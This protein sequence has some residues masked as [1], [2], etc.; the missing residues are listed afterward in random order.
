[1]K[2]KLILLAIIIISLGFRL[3]GLD[4]DQNQHLHPDER[5][6]TMVLD[7]MR[8]PATID[9]YLDPHLSLL[10]P[11]NLDF[12]FFV[13]GTLPLIVTRIVGEWANMTSYWNIY[14]IGRILSAIADL[15]TLI[16]VFK[17]TR[18]LFDSKTA[19][20]SALCYGLMVL[21][22]QLSHFFAVDT[23]LNFFLFLSLYLLLVPAL[24]GS[25]FKP[26]LGTYLLSIFSSTSFALALSSKVS[27]L[28]FSPLVA[29]VFITYFL[30]LKRQSVFHRLTSLIPLG[31][32]YLISAVF[33]FRLVQPQV[34]SSSNLLDFHL[35]PQFISNI[36]E[37]KLYSQPDTWFPP[38]IQW[39]TTT[40][41]IFPLVN[42]IKWGLGIPLF[43]LFVF[44]LI[45]FTLGLFSKPKHNSSIR[46]LITIFILVWAA[47]F[48]AYQ[49]FQFVKSMRYF[50]VVYPII[51]IISGIGLEYLWQRPNRRLWLMA[52]IL[53]AV[54][55]YPVSFMSI[56]SHPHSR[57]TASK[58]IY[59]NIDSGS[60]LTNEHW[61]DGLPVNL[62]NQSRSYVHIELPM[63][64]QDTPKKWQEV[65]P[66]L[67]EAD[68]LVMS[69]NRLYGTIPKH[70]Q[71]Y[72]LSS[73]Y[74][75]L[76][77]KDRF[78][79]YTQVA[80]F[81]SRPCFPPVGKSWFCYQDDN[82]EEAFTVYDHPRVLIYRKT[83]PGQILSNF[84][85]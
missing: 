57:I 41:V 5:F 46:R 45:I 20:F 31:S 7:K 38:S 77:L 52:L 79:G 35:N 67:N 16:L 68:Y 30:R 43:T 44:S 27:A 2:T 34:F 48:F 6:L 58:W 12:S 66:K 1:M 39:K 60:R 63:F 28:Y 8:L 21:P 4:W 40:P 33:I 69:S 64:D 11:Y 3:Y 14:L 61:D 9:Q 75:D 13:Y 37:L 47:L 50:L 42:L 55:L 25:S 74:Y 49:G 80:E 65:I 26:T 23:F 62:P 15:G 85:P 84:V 59:Q 17:I 73:R 22:I 70:P 56:Y 51:A 54:S 36:K 53:G 32:V 72:P 29:L 71:Y 24:K 82:A 19:L 83:N 81:T 10:N 76:L 78:K 18:L